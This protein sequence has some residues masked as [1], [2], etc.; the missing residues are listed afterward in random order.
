[1]V[2]VLVFLGTYSL[3][4][5]DLMAGE[6][7]IDHAP[8]RSP[9]KKTADRELP[10]A[11]A[12]ESQRCGWARSAGGKIRS[13]WD[14]LRRHVNGHLHYERHPIHKEG[15]RLRELW[16]DE[17]A[18]CQETREALDRYLKHAIRHSLVD[19]HGLRELC[20]KVLEKDPHRVQSKVVKQW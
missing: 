18:G 8:G 2:M 19:A 9:L 17:D 11:G 14:F 4:S 13:G 6:Q 7:H 12:Q 10:P 1:M 15:V 3:T 16:A 20:M 5:I